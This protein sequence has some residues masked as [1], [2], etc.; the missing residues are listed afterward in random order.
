M[1]AVLTSM[2]TVPLL[3]SP[4]QAIV[5]DEDFDRVA[6]FRWYVEKDAG[7][8]YARAV[9]GGKVVRMHRFL[10]TAQ[11]GQLVDHRDGDGLN[12]TRENLRPCTHSQNSANR[13]KRS[14][15]R[16]RYKGI[17]WHKRDQ[18][19]QAVI[20]ARGHSHHLGNFATER[21]AALA[22]NAAARRLHGE[23]ASLNDVSL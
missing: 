18:R 6:A 13:R 21:A 11:P 3:H 8:V 16:S 23:F 5:D 1:L 10:T 22:Y 14:S 7:R 20:Y 4:L 15:T 9:I 17:R 2:R 19:W 12:N